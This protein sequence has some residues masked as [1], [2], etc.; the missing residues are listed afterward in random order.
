MDEYIIILPLD[1]IGLR[2]YYY[3]IRQVEIVWLVQLL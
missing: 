1:F 3:I 2:S